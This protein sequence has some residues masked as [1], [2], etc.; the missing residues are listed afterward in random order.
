LI[1]NHSSDSWPTLGPNH[2]L[3]SWSECD[4][5]EEAIHDYLNHEPDPQWN[6][7]WRALG[8]IM[9]EY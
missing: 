2:P 5:L 3:P 8:A 1:Q 7:I 4:Q 6:D 9:G